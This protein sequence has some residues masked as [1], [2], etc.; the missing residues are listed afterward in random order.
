MIRVSAIAAAAL[1]ALL[2]AAWFDAG[3][4]EPHLIVQPAALP[5][6]AR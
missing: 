4:E 2:A 5:V 3:R 6:P 1:V